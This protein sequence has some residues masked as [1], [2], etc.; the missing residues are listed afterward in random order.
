[1]TDMDVDV[2]I[3]NIISEQRLLE[4]FLLYTFTYYYYLSVLILKFAIDGVA[5]VEETAKL[6]LK[7]LDELIA[8]LLALFFVSM[9]QRSLT[10]T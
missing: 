5:S 4:S 6:K 9:L 7:S 2:V 1:M 8:K 10:P 3:I